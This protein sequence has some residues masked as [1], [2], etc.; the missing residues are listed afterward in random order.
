MNI[1]ALS[2][3]LTPYSLATVSSV[4]LNMLLAFIL[5][6][7]I[8]AI[9]KWTHTGMPAETFTNTLIILCMLISV[10]MVVIGESVARAFSLVGALS[11]I[12]FRTVVRDPRDIAFVFFAL[13]IGMGVGAGNPS[14]SII[15]TFL[16]GTVILGLHGWQ[17]NNADKQGFLVTFR[18]PIC[19]E[20][21]Q[22][23]QSVFNDQLSTYRRLSR[24]ATSSGTVE[25]EYRVKLKHPEQWA[26][27]IQELLITE[28]IT[29]VKATK[30]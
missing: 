20:F 18:V 22:Y 7:V 4:S 14:V 13:A 24:K 11:I 3:L 25:L 17:T 2:K 10:V 6:L 26:Q 19:D 29:K 21:E 9:Y 1:D 16:I 12:R 27:F 30:F 15:G 8:A 5:G 28:D 23:Y